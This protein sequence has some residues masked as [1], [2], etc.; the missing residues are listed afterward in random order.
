MEVIMS[1]KVKISV[2]LEPEVA[3]AVKV[4]A[5][6]Q[7]SGVSDIVS[8]IFLCAH[9]RDPISDEFIVGIPKMITPDWYG[10]FFHKNRKAC[11]AASGAS[12]IKP[13]KPVS[14]TVAK[15]SSETSR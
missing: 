2:F 7:G 14:K 10:V 4:Q 13:K 6:R 15:V 8:N 12:P 11:L 9:C 3:K 1:D 5:A